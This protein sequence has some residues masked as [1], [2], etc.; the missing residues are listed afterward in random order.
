MM[1]SVRRS[2]LRN[3]FSR[4]DFLGSMMLDYCF[5]VEVGEIPDE[6]KVQRGCISVNG[7][8]NKPG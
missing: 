6:G 7:R 1:T 5:C 2:W 3:L 8:S 4:G